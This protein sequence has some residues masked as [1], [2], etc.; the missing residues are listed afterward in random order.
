M[1]PS[2]YD[3]NELSISFSYFIKRIWGDV[4]QRTV[5]QKKHRNLNFPLGRIFI[6]EF[7]LFNMTSFLFVF[8]FSNVE[9]VK[10]VE[11]F[12]IDEITL[13]MSFIEIFDFVL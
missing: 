12:N 3:A 4:E 2:Y 1:I 10:N 13:I 9:Y 8:F 7:L 6:K 5:S 11:Y